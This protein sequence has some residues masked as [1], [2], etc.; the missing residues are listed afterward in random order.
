MEKVKEIE[1]KK[2][3]FKLM[4]ESVSHVEINFDGEG[5]SGE[6]HEI[7]YYVDKMFG[8]NHGKC[9]DHMVDDVAYDLIYEMVNEYGGDWYNGDGGY[10][11]VH[12]HVMEQHI[13][14][15]YNQRT[16][17]EYFWNERDR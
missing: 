9:Y 12:I 8:T 6:I 14:G 5:D 17:D 10:G 13:E 4:D 3:L 16:V 1:T 2:V 7:N 15:K 11:H